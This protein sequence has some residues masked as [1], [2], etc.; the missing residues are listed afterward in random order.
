MRRNIGHIFNKLQ[1]DY[2]FL[3]PKSLHTFL[4][5]VGEIDNSSRVIVHNSGY[6]HDIRQQSMISPGL[7]HEKMGKEWL[8]KNVKEA[9]KYGAS[10]SSSKYFRSL[11]TAFNNSRVPCPQELSSRKHLYLS[12]LT[13]ETR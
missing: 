4:C 9:V 5:L 6:N 7:V 11:C 2:A 12:N 1:T 8:G 13:N 10:M 3:R